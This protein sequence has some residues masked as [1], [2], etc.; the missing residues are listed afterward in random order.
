MTMTTT[1]MSAAATMIDRREWVLPGKF[2]GG[3]NTAERNSVLR[4]RAAEKTGTR[5]CN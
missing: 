4:V 3:E 2:T 1:T 5:L